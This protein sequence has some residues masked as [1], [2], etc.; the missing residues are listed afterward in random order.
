MARVPN[1]SIY[2]WMYRQGLAM[3]TPEEVCLDL[4]CAGR[5][6]RDKDWRN[7]LAGWNN[8]TRPRTNLP[9]EER[10]TMRYSD[11]P[12][13]TAPVP[14]RSWVPCN[15]D[16]KPMIPWGSYCMS[17]VDA[18]CT[19]GCV[20]LAQNL[21]HQ[22][23]IVID[24]DGDHDGTP[25]LEVLRHYWRYLWKTAAIAKPKLLWEYG[26]ACDECEKEMPASFHLMFS[27]NR[28]IP[29]MHF[30]KVDVIGNKRNSLRYLKNKVSNHLD[31]MP[32]T[33]EIWENVV[34]WAAARKDKS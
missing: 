3:R 21:L 16:N 8:A 23:F 12:L 11:Y 33:D 27:V 13:A 22:R 24:V 26:C 31:L 34:I 2:L 1:G 25:D 30:P 14:E 4:A 18:S 6:I 5:A 7:Y 19:L 9:W 17:C 32:M 10:R 20:Y 29:T 15:K 28:E